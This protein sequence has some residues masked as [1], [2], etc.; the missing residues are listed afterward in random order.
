MS[1]RRL[2]AMSVLPILAV[3][4]EYAYRVPLAYSRVPFSYQP[5]NLSLSKIKNV[6]KRPYP[7][8]IVMAH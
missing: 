4:M 6:Q 5:C 3:S 8:N 1:V 2:G 7:S